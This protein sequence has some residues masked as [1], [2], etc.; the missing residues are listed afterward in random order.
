MNWSAWRTGSVVRKVRKIGTTRASERR[1]EIQ[2]GETDSAG[3]RYRAG[4]WQTK[5]G[6]WPAGAS[7]V[8]TYVN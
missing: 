3:A 1:P 7:I 2:S 8:L 4:R 5:E 6:E